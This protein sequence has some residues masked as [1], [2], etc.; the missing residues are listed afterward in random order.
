[1]D[2][3]AHFYKTDFQVHTPRDA[4]WSGGDAVTDTERKDYAEELILAC[5]QKGI[6]AIA[7]TDHHDFAFFPYVK[8]AAKSE[9]DDNGHLIPVEKRIIVFPGLELTLTAPNC[10]AILLLD[11]EF[12]TN[13]L[14]S[15]LAT[16]CI[17]A[18]P[19]SDSKTANVV[20]IAQSVVADLSDLYKKLDDQPGVKGRFIILPNVSEGGNRTILRS[21]F[22]NFY[23]N[24]P[25]VGGYVD[26]S[27]KQWG[28]GNRD[29]VAGKNRDYGFK[30]IAVFQTSDNRSRL[31]DRLGEYV[32]WV[33]WA[34]PT[35]EAIRQACLAKESRITNT[36]PQL[37]DFWISDLK[38][39][40]S[41]FMGRINVDFNRQ[42]NSI[43][44][45]R[46]T[47]K[48]TILEYLRWGLCDQ[49]VLDDDSEF[50]PVHERRTKLIQDTL[51]AFN[52]EV[53]VTFLRNNITHIVKRDASTGDAQ[54]KIGDGEFQE[55]A[56]NQIRELLPVQAYSQK[57]LSSV[58]V[59]IE[60]LKRFVEQ[61]VRQKLDSLKS[62]ISDVA[63][64]LRSSYGK[65][66]R[67][68]D[69][70]FELKK[71]ELELSSLQQQLTELQSSLKGLS[72]EDKK[73]IEQK[74]RWDTEESIV[75]ELE[76]QLSSLRTT[77]ASLDVDELGPDA[78]TELS[79]EEET[80]TSNLINPKEIKDIEVAYEKKFSEIREQVES[81]KSL[82]SVDALNEITKSVDKWREK[83]NTF[84]TQYEQAQQR[85]TSNKKQIEQI[86]ATEARISEVKKKSKERQGELEKLGTPEEEYNSSVQTWIMLHRKKFEVLKG[87]CDKFT[88][89]SGNLIRASV[90]KGLDE[91]RMKQTLKSALARMS[92]REQR[93][94]ELYKEV[95]Q[96]EDIFQS[97][98]SI[99]KE[100][101]LLSM[102][103]PETTKS[104]PKTP[105]LD[106]CGFTD[107]EKLRITEKFD[108][109]KWLSLSLVELE[110][111]PS[112]EY[113]TSKK[114]DEYISFA[115]ASA[116]QQ[117]T[118][119]ISVLL[120]QDGAPLIIDQP[121]D[122]IDSSAVGE[123]V[124]RIWEAKQNRQLLF[125]SHNANFV[126][127]GDAELVICCDYVKA[128]DQTGGTIKTS[129]AID[130]AEIR[131]E[132]TRVTEGGER[133][134]KLRKEKYGF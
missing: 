103:N 10:Q 69:L 3:G 125:A 80:N 87:E 7:I 64:T 74:I 105:I 109:N 78:A 20:R 4:N 40:N 55:V 38:V 86:R 108:R 62:Q 124:E 67:R 66:I 14:P 133:A 99:L 26:G 41:K 68:N 23:K 8:E 45:G 5:R 47:G 57:Q 117:A 51:A 15:I 72:A 85:A 30:S 129:G 126:V 49:P 1:M 50:A 73:T 39:S 132:I 9:V 113:C 46:G 127:N 131:E 114:T 116:G 56:A 11:A 13:L 63:V 44:G 91:R 76:Q 115:D 54:L 107:S 33:K 118:A 97:W 94:D 17:K 95:V 27:V 36:E 128:G 81:L 120:N 6:G 102:H 52:A 89:L 19:D 2:K 60:E 61:P 134:F 31:H 12:P 96:A 83:H 43:I 104:F 77:I 21:G 25:C 100:F 59:R 22:A 75:E 32:T 93:I 18:A 53:Q 24:M 34:Q 71:S 37:P 29:I 58:G 112:F 98:L 35:A 84:K 28:V 65:V 121:E 119:L 130:I 106:K 90:S 123:I 42:Y 110:F 92:V 111:V 88:R 70:V 122:D 48:S 79:E 82:I 16:L 101:E